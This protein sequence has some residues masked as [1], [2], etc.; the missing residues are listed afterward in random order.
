M[1]IFILVL[2][3]VSIV[4]VSKVS[5]FDICLTPSATLNI[6]YTGKLPPI[7]L[8]L[9]GG[10]VGGQLFIYLG[11]MAMN[12]LIDVNDP[13]FGLLGILVG[14]FFSFKASIG[15]GLGVKPQNAM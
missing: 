15:V 3:I 2:S 9:R 6:G 11:S 13:P 4:A 7:L 14:S 1:K 12:D 8:Y 5:A 10:T